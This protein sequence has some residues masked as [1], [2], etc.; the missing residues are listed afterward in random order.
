MTQPG[1]AAMNGWNW[2]LPSLLSRVP[3]PVTM[4]FHGAAH[5]SRC[6]ARDLGT[7]RVEAIIVFAV[8]LSRIR[9]LRSVI[10]VERG[11][12]GRASVAAHAAPAAG[13]GP[14]AP[15]VAETARPGGKTRRDAAA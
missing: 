8:E 9:G 7:D 3:G 13:A 2:S 12:P 5:R 10:G 1:A 11:P 4:L 15:P 14:A 6:P